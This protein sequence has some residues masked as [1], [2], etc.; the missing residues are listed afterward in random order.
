MTYPEKPLSSIFIDKSEYA[1]SMVPD[2]E[3]PWLDSISHAI[4]EERERIASTQDSI[5][6]ARELKPPG[7]SFAN[8]ATGR[9]GRLHENLR[10]GNVRS[11]MVIF[12]L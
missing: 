1:S 5:V 10:H 12:C 9:D 4:K 11:D 2:S 8:E 7:G 3:T 6:D